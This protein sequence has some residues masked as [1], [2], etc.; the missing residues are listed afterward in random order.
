VY[1]RLKVEKVWILMPVCGRDMHKDT[2]SA[3]GFIVLQNLV[4]K[5]ERRLILLE[6]E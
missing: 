1:T 5:V 4:A 3:M 2:H 6:R